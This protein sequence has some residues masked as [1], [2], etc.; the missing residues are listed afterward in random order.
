MSPAQQSPEKTNPVSTVGLA[1]QPRVVASADTDDV[2]R[3]QLEYLIEHA[4]AGACGCSQCQRY[5]R[6]RSILMEVFG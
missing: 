2:L 4:H 5:Q 1:T 6:A 3:E